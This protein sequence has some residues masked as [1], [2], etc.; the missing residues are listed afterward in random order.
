MKFGSETDS[1][2]SSP[3]DKNIAKVLEQDEKGVQTQM[4]GS[5]NGFQKGKKLCFIGDDIVAVDEEVKKEAVELCFMPMDIPEAD[6]QLMAMDIT[7]ADSKVVKEGPICVSETS[8]L[9]SHE[10]L[11]EERETLIPST[12]TSEDYK[13]SDPELA[14]ELSRHE[15]VVDVIEMENPSIDCETREED[16]FVRGSFSSLDVECSVTDSELY[17]D[18]NVTEVTERAMDCLKENSDNVVKDICIDEGLPTQ[19]KLPLSDNDSCCEKICGSL[20]SDVNGDDDLTRNAGTGV[21]EVDAC[22]SS[23]SEA[24]EDL[25]SSILLED[26]NGEDNDSAKIFT[27]GDLLQE[28]KSESG[29]FEKRGNKS[30]EEN[31]TSMKPVSMQDLDMEERVGPTSSESN[32]IVKQQATNEVGSKAEVPTVQCASD[33][34]K[35]KSSDTEALPT[36]NSKVENGSTTLDFESQEGQMIVEKNGYKGGG[37]EHQV[38]EA[39]SERNLVGGEGT[40]TQSLVHHSHGLSISDRKSWYNDPTDLTG[41]VSGQIP[42][43][44][45][46]PYS[47]SI[48]LRSDS[49]TTSTRSFA[50]PILHSEWNSSPVKMAQ[51][52]RRYR[53]HRR[54]RIGLLC[55]SK[56]CIW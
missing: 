46:I 52:D 1:C 30:C 38:T 23:I 8:S 49:S 37:D 10:K 53:K 5:E 55:C 3:A 13:N 25:Q 39:S 32:D 17:T 2:Y 29:S 40:T 6:S 11:K 16:K 26:L 47:G 22:A 12:I 48:S 42:Y 18:K 33:Q 20:H 43:S 19:N 35:V 34:I 56:H 14:E 50:F 41:S 9:G 28:Q 27:L 51:P 24:K 45:P 7:R 15:S 21:S 44:G 36:S 54:W 4:V 31:S